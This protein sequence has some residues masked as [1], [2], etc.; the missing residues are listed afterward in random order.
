MVPKASKNA[1]ATVELLKI[2]INKENG[3]AF[4]LGTGYNPTRKSAG[5][6]FADL[7]GFDQIAEIYAN[8]EQVRGVVHE[9]VSA[10]FGPI[11]QIRQKILL[12]KTSV[13]D[14]LEEMK[15]L[16]QKDLEKVNS[17]R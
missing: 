2:L 17:S 8:Y 12:N 15:T 3:S 9:V 13:D 14:G 4:A 6:V 10:D 16:L 7:K 5:N 11:M 1:D